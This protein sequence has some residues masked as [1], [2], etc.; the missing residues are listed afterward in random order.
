MNGKKGDKGLGSLRR[1]EKDGEKE[2]I[3]EDRIRGRSSKKVETERDGDSKGRRSALQHA[4]INPFRG[5]GGKTAEDAHKEK[6]WTT[7]SG[8]P[9]LRGG[10]LNKSQ[11]RKRSAGST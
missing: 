1:Q 8:K 6:N 7:N 11:Q 9:Y 3:V 2:Q 4:G 5:I 10:T